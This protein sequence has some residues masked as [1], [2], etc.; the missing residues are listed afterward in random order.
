MSGDMAM[1]KALLLT[2]RLALLKIGVKSAPRKLHRRTRKVRSKVARISSALSPK[3]LS[4]SWLARHGGANGQLGGCEFYS[5]P[6]KPG[7]ICFMP[8][9]VGDLFA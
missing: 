1:T 9:G 6:R 3:A 4:K 5:E 2:S 7:G 8:V